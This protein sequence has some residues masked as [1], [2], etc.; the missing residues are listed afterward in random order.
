[1]VQFVDD[2]LAAPV[3]GDVATDFCP[4][5]ELK[6]QSREQRLKFFRALP[7][8]LLESLA[9]YHWFCLEARFLGSSPA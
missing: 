4:L 3:A 5:C 2:M 1:M 9:V 7:R 8:E 6:R